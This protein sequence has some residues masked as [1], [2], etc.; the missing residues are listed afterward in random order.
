MKIVGFFGDRQWLHVKKL[1]KLAVNPP[2]VILAEIC[3]IIITEVY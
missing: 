2:D 3:A 1:G